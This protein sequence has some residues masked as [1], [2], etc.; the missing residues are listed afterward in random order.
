MASE[1]WGRYLLIVEGGL[2]Q[3]WNNNFKLE[4]IRNPGYFMLV[5]GPEETIIWARHGSCWYINYPLKEKKKLG[6][7][8]KM[9]VTAIPAF[10][11]FV[12]NSVQP[13]FVG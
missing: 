6:V 13:A 3:T 7:V 12:G 1:D 11:V 4:P 5:T 2:A 8:L 9:D 10:S